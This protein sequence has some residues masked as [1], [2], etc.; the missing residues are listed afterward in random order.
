MNLLTHGTAAQVKAHKEI[1][2]VIT[3][4]INRESSKYIWSGGHRGIRK[5]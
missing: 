1:K 2:Q 3:F 4:D 5:Y